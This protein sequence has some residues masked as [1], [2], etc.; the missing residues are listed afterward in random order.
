MELEA[1]GAF[2]DAGNRIALAG[3]AAPVRHSAVQTLALALHELATNARKHGGFSRDEGRLGV[4]WRVREADGE[5][6]RLVLEWAETGTELPIDTQPERRGYGRELIERALPYAV[7][8]K[9][10][11]E[12]RPEGVRCTID[13]PLDKK[14][15]RRRPR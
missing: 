12:L 2:R 7:G 13:M 5:G 10:S 11:Y 8:A 9:T 1:L 4:T 6:R 3:P 15:R 14:E